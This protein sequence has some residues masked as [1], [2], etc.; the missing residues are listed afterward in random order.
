[1]SDLKTLNISFEVEKES[2]LAKTGKVKAWKREILTP[3][4][5]FGLSIIESVDFQ[6]NVF[7]NNNVEGI[8]CN[9]YDLLFQ[10]KSERKNLVV[11]LGKKL[12]VKCDS[13]GF[14]NM[15]SDTNISVKQV[16]NLQKETESDIYV[17]LDYPLFPLNSEA[18]NFRRIDKTFKNL[19]E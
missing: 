5:W 16:Y 18:V 8:L 4:K 11:D 19:E 6:L 10:D 7:S 13:G 14:Q 1:M 9:A 17:Q 3:F 15:N 12:A 2:R